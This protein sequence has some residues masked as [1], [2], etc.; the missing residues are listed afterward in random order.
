MTCDILSLK[1]VT[2]NGSTS[3]YGG[4]LTS[5]SMSFNGL[6]SQVKAT[7][8][9]VGA[10][11][12]PK[13]GDAVT[14]KIMGNT[15]LKMQVGGY[16]S[17]S[18][19]TAAD[20]MT[21]TL[22]DTSNLYLDNR[23]IVLKEEVPEAGGIP[24]NVW[25]MGIKYG[26]LPSAALA[27]NGV[28]TANSD[29]QWGDL[30]NFYELET[31]DCGEEDD[32]QSRINQNIKGAPGKTLWPAAGDPIYNDYGSI[33]TH[34]LESALGD[35]LGKGS[36]IVGG[37]FD[38]KGTFRDVIVQYCNALGLQAWWDLETEEI[39]IKETSN[40]DDGFAILNEIKDQ[41]EVVSASSNIDYTTTLAKGAIGSITSSYPGEN[42]ASS[43]REQS[44]FLRATALRPVFKY[45]TCANKATNTMTELGFGTPVLKAI[46]AAANPKL[47]AAYALQSAFLAPDPGG[48]LGQQGV[49]DHNDKQEGIR[50]A[51]M[52]QA[53]ELCNRVE[54][55]G[56]SKGIVKEFIKAGIL[57]LDEDN[58]GK[59]DEKLG[60]NQRDLD[61][62]DWAALLP[63]DDAPDFEGNTFLANYFA[64]DKDLLRTCSAQLSTVKIGSLKAEKGNP[65]ADP[66]VPGKPA[67]WMC[68][69]LEN[70]A[71][72]PPKVPADI[73]KAKEQTPQGWNHRGD[74][75]P[76]KTM[77]AFT[78]T[79]IIDPDP[80][81]G[82]DDG[83]DDEMTEMTEMMKKRKS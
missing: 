83:D 74:Q 71:A 72:S 14:V 63:A 12:G 69:Q 29:T 26:P 78:T 16:D 34:S 46:Q 10:T 25:V 68:R 22:Y 28:I 73:G 77:G 31:P 66:A 2:L 30:R 59:L 53:V 82:G 13:A 35:L 60:P 49:D 11:E 24:D 65:D 44:K 36:E 4:T 33:K 54:M 19:A 37:E 62:E 43:G 6:A 38:F 20:T 8:T 81:D 27:K 47:F 21:L 80:P 39:I 15:E 58:D 55:N 23:H 51:F 42:Q 45:K 50:S 52:D 1:G 64:P 75:D 61:A 5:F 17:K 40:V 32:K 70:A 41:C 76:M 3:A 48:P 9:L 56:V 79:A 7:A 18:S 67:V 57:V